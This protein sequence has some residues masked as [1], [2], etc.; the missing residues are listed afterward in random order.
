MKKEKALPSSTTSTYLVIHHRLRVS[1][2]HFCACQT[3]NTNLNRYFENSF[4]ISLSEFSDRASTDEEHK[5]TIH[6]HERIELYT[7]L[8][9]QT[10]GSLNSR[11]T[12]NNNNKWSIKIFPKLQ[13]GIKGG[14][15]ERKNYRN[16]QIYMNENIIRDKQL[17]TIV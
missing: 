16:P 5:P 8:F 2:I 9:R 10:N 12:N 11:D 14:I 3:A 7:T 6:K 13:K 17:E 4:W 1:T 15:D